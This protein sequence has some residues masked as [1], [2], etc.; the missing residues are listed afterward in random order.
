MAS[1]RSTSSKEEANPWS[2]LEAELEGSPKESSEA[3][4][5]SSRPG[6]G[7]TANNTSSTSDEEDYYGKF[8]SIMVLCE[9]VHDHW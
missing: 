4:S 9:L 1:P 6:Q 3:S 8:G 2:D 5:G 7:S